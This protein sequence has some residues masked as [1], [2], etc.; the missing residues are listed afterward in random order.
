MA[1]TKYWEDESAREALIARGR[2]VMD[3]IR[4]RLADEQGVV[5]IEPD[6]GAFFCGATL[7]K[8][9]DAAYRH[10]PDRWLYFARVDDPDAQI[11]LP[12]W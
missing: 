5:A 11:V 8:A 12:A 9:N 7:G 10:Y 2:A 6:S 4:D 3:G 1:E